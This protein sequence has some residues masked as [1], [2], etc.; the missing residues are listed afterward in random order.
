[1]T[2][3]TTG[4]NTARRGTGRAYG[5]RLLRHDLDRATPATAALTRVATRV[6]GATSAAA[7]A[8]AERNERWTLVRDASA[9]AKIAGAS[10]S[11]FATAAARPA[12]TTA[13]LFTGTAHSVTPR[14]SARPISSRGWDLQEAAREAAGTAAARVCTLCHPAAHI[15]KSL[16]FNRSGRKESDR[17]RASKADTDSLGDADPGEA[18][19]TDADHPAAAAVCRRQLVIAHSHEPAIAHCRRYRALISVNHQ[20]LCWGKLDLGFVKPRW[21]YAV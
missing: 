3:S 7:T 2:A 1:L 9:A 14:T 19:H 17:A 10:V 5:N 13:R 20:V 21:I 8:T 18:E 15:E 4:M 12:A 16:D 6:A 11:P